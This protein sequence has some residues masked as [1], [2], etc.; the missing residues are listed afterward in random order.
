[1]SDEPRKRPHDPKQGQQQPTPTRD[2][3]KDS[4]N[5]RGDVNK[6][7]PGKVQPIEQWSQPK[8]KNS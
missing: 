2:E 7:V 6:S 4:I 3:Q 8:K 5:K 1:M